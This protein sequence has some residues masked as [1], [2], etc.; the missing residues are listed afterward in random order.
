MKSL[1]RLLVIPIIFAFLTACSGD[2]NTAATDTTTTI[3]G[4]VTAP[5]G[6]ISFNNQPPSLQQRLASAI[7]GNKAHAVVSGSSSVG[8]GVTVELIEIDAAGNKVGSTIESTTTDADGKY[9]LKTVK[10]ASSKFIIRVSG[11]TESMD[12]RYTGTTN[13]VDPVSDAVS[14]LITAATSDLSKMS[15]DEVIEIADSVDGLV[16]AIDPTGLTDKYVSSSN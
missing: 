4:A 2:S 11:T 1:V 8:S 10:P 9:T 15:T 3:T 5:S 13:D 12:V 7:F 16:S 14:G 6:A